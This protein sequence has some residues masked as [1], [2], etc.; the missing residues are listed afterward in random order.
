MAMGNRRR[1]ASIGGVVAALGALAWLCLS[2]GGELAPALRAV[3]LSAF[4]L[5]TALHGLTLVAR[6]EAWRLS[7]A[8]VEDR[9]PPRSAVHGANAGA[10]LIGAVDSHGALPVRVV[11]LR[12]L[13]P[14]T[15]P[16]PVQI[17]VADIPIFLLEVCTTALMLALATA[18]GPLLLVGALLVVLAGRR[19][20]GRLTGLAVL[21]DRRRRAGLATWV[22]AITALALVRTAVALHAAGLEAGVADVAL[23]CATMGALGLLPLGPSAAPAATMASAGSG[24]GALAAGLV[25]AAGALVA[26]AGY[27]LAVLAL[28]VV[29]RETELSDGGSECSLLRRS[30]ARLARSGSTSSSA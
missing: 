14:A 2:R 16:R 1:L 10:F 27:A 5:V 24:A 26:V 8:A 30:A 17:A 15:A 4:V 21:A 13:A 3:P 28:L 11:L 6:S 12:R 18:L 22:G 7:L 9:V 23:T 20:C 29:L 25:V 19:F